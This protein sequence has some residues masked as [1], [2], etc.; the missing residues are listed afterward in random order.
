MGVANWG[1][2]VNNANLTDGFFFRQTGDSQTL[3]LMFTG[4]K[5]PSGVDLYYSQF[6][7]TG[8]FWDPYY[9]QI[10]QP[11]TLY[12]NG[13]IVSGLDTG[14][15]KARM[16]MEWSGSNSNSPRTP[17]VL[18]D[19]QLGADFCV[20]DPDF[21]AWSCSYGSGSDTTTAGSTYSVTGPSF[22]F[23]PGDVLVM[24]TYLPTDTTISGATVTA[25]GVT[26]D[27]LDT[28]VA[29]TSVTGNDMS[30]YVHVCRVATNSATATAAPVLSFTETAS[31]FSD[32]LTLFVR[33]RGTVSNNW[34]PM[35][36]A[37]GGG[38]EFDFTGTTFTFDRSIWTDPLYTQT[39]NGRGY[40][41]GGDLQIVSVAAKPYTVNWNT[42]AGWTKYG[43]YTSGTAAS[44]AD[45]GGTS[46]TYFVRQW[47]E[48]INETQVFT[49]T[50]ASATVGMW[51][52]QHARTQF[53]KY[54]F[55]VITTI[56]DTDV[57]T[58]SI[59]P[60]SSLEAVTTLR[61]WDNLIGMFTGP[62][63][64]ASPGDL[65]YPYP[66]GWDADQ[67][68]TGGDIYNLS[69]GLAGTT[70]GHDLGIMWQM[71]TLS[72]GDG[73]AGTP[74]T[75]AVGY[76]TTGTGNSSVDSSGQQQWLSICSDR[77]KAQATVTVTPAV[78]VLLSQAPQERQIT[79]TGASTSAGSMD[80]IV[81]LVGSSDA[82][83]LIEPSFGS[84]SVL[85]GSVAYD[86]TSTLASGTGT[87][88]FDHTPV[89][90]PKGVL[91]LIVQNG[92][93]PDQTTAVTYGGDAM[94]GVGEFDDVTEAGAVSA[95]FLGTSIPTGVAS[96]Q[97]TRSSNATYFAA[98]LTVTSS[99][100]T[101][102]LDFDGG[103]IAAGN[104]MP[105]SLV[106]PDY[107]SAFV[108]GAVFSG[109]A[110]TT[111]V[112]DA[113]NTIDEIS[114][115]FGQQ[116]GMI[117]RMDSIIPGGQT[118]TGLGWTQSNDDAAWIGVAIG[119]DMP[120]YHE[121][122]WT[123]TITPTRSATPAA[124]EK[125]G[126]G[127]DFIVNHTLAAAGSILY[128]YIGVPGLLNA[129]PIL[130]AEAGPVARTGT[131][132]ATSVSPASMAG[133]AVTTVF[134]PLIP[135]GDPRPAHTASNPRLRQRQ[136]PYR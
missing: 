112:I 116:V 25:T 51:H 21:N 89:G 107:T 54:K 123:L 129:S 29:T 2:Y 125:V 24:C 92:A 47:Y 55:E 41:R 83:I 103:V 91:V 48:G 78:T 135:S 35:I 117:D 79:A 128:T 19:V 100:D 93:Q 86:A 13:S 20:Q 98:C 90:D 23:A 69:P 136:S 130:T 43:P 115:D 64:A 8:P 18:P 32:G 95:W 104:D 39:H 37:F 53:K 30:Q 70:L 6:N 73:A 99:G 101:E 71:L 34:R 124:V 46:M 72:A 56:P 10:I 126:I 16:A 12:S 102:V 110:A 11:A 80:A 59:G 1:W 120:V 42:P 94:V 77:W 106:L 67:R 81:S 82:H 63:D 74:T 76:F 9:T 85:S 122:D 17:T 65:P 22:A 114:V 57:S 36:F 60:F 68:H 119:R 5:G 31:G 45:H 61:S 40:L 33:A 62:T 109:E 50:G 108:A 113:A 121:S 26:F 87:R 127:V 3:L 105:V 131:A 97:I 118:F 96:V 44:S 58:S 28:L 66:G 49:T 88:S 15:M 75:N 52:Y 7:P 84:N 4:G 132:T 14:S 133:G 134:D 27:A 111:S 38:T